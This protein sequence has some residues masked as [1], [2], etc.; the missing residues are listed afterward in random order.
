MRRI[1]QPKSHGEAATCS[2]VHPMERL[3]QWP[4]AGHVGMAETRLRVGRFASVACTSPSGIDRRRIHS[5]GA[6]THA[7]TRRLVLADLDRR[8]ERRMGYRAPI[9]CGPIAFVGAEPIPGWLARLSAHSFL[10]REPTARWP[11]AY[12][13]IACEPTVLR[14]RTTKESF[15]TPDGAKRPSLAPR[16]SRCGAVGA[17]NSRGTARLLRHPLQ[18]VTNHQRRP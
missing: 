16:A 17:A 5:P 10:G 11:G 18:E 2:F 7:I 6:R 1:R 15:N 12:K 8:G 9:A 3:Q 4:P 13:L 14:T